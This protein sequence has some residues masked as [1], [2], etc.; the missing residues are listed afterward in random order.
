ME[1]ELQYK[2]NEFYLNSNVSCMFLK[3]TLI[4]INKETTTPNAK[5]RGLFSVEFESHNKSVRMYGDAFFDENLNI[6]KMPSEYGNNIVGIY[7]SN[8]TI[9]STEINTR[10]DSLILPI[11]LNHN[12]YIEQ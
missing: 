11:F 10:T 4:E 1:M 7:I 3:S 5:Y 12:K 2:L 8:G 9:N 6:T